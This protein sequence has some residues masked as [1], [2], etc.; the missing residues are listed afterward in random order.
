MKHWLRFVLVLAAA[1][2]LLAC[3]SSDDEED[4]GILKTPA[5]NLIGTYR[6]NNVYVSYPGGEGITISEGI[7]GELRITRTAA[8][9]TITIDGKR[10][11]AAGTYDITWNGSL[12]GTVSVTSSSGTSEF[13]FYIFGMT[14]VIDYGEYPLADWGTD[15]REL[16][17]WVKISNDEREADSDE[18]KVGN[19]ASPP[20]RG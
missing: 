13:P 6:L 12:G 3:G 16:I 20:A 7:Q 4:D 19:V 5:E 14:V 18:G 8:Y 10:Y 17:E 15:A 2:L 9:Q 11:V 1:L